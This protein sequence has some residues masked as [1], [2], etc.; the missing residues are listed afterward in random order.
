MRP[1][2]RF[3]RHATP[4]SPPCGPCRAPMR[5]SCHVACY[6]L[7]FAP[8]CHLRAPWGHLAP[9]TVVCALHHAPCSRL[10]PAVVVCAP[11]RVHTGP[12]YRLRAP[13][14]PLDVPRRCLLPHAAVFRRAAPSA[15]QAT[16]GAI[17]GARLSPACPLSCPCNR[18]RLPVRLLAP[19]RPVSRTYVSASTVSLPTFPSNPPVV[20]PSPL[21]PRV[22]L[23]GATRTAS[24][25]L[26]RCLTL[27]LALTRTASY[28]PC[29]HQVFCPCAPSRPCAPRIVP[30]RPMSPRSRSVPFIA[31]LRPRR[32]AVS[33][34][35]RSPCRLAR[36]SATP[37]P[38]V[39]SRPLAP[40]RAH[41][42]ASPSRRHVEPSPL[43]RASRG[44][45]FAQPPLC[46]PSATL[47]PALARHLTKTPRA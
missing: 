6:L 43:A 42:A 21:C 27:T 22:A 35:L 44:A 2:A 46:A 14:R 33:P 26:S 13:L 34:H 37:R 40:Y 38:H 5:P 17:I 23:A 12:S 8:P 24:H 36:Q 11:R 3:Q 28:S 39:S 16:E 10:M 45:V 29:R 9:F 41:R 30:M 1:A 4:F 7:I 20:L 15:T 18:P 19:A 47:S 25:S 31:R 32:S